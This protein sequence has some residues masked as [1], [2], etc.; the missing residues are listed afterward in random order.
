[1]QHQNSLHGFFLLSME[2]FFAPQNQGH[3]SS[4]GCLF[5]IELQAGGIR[6]NWDDEQL[7][8]EVGSNECTVSS[9][10]LLPRYNLQNKEKR[11]VLDISPFSL[12]CDQ[13]LTNKLIIVTDLL[14][15]WNLTKT[16]QKKKIYWRRTLS[17][18]ASN[19][20]QL[21]NFI[22]LLLSTLNANTESTCMA[23]IVWLLVYRF[24]RNLASLEKDVTLLSRKVILVSNSATEKVRKE[25]TGGH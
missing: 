11:K 8:A 6:E 20:N 17:V 2:L 24:E 7:E 23:A 12:L 18:V 16:A 13:I 1:M 14:H 10:F 25:S 3:H 15:R 22:W 19:C 9:P 4:S 5:F 21:P